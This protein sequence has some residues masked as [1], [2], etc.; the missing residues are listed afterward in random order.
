MKS[1]SVTIQMKA[2]EQSVPVVLFIMLYKVVFLSLDGIPGYNHSSESFCEY[3][4]VVL[5]ILC[6]SMWF[7]LLSLSVAMAT[8]TKAIELY[9]PVV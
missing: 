7:Q 5:F 1:S 9:C 3:D 4:F 8:Q 6:C 2:T